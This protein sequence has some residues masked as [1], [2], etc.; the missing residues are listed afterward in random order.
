MSED[1]E[2]PIL[3]LQWD[4]LDQQQMQDRIDWCRENLLAGE[5]WGF[6]AEHRICVIKNKSSSL[7]YQ[8]RWFEYGEVQKGYAEGLFVYG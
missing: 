3:I 8:L 7:A 4:Q 2:N 6:C 5:D 1:Y